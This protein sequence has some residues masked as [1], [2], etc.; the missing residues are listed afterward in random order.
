MTWWLDYNEDTCDGISIFSNNKPNIPKI[1][2]G[3]PVRN[4]EWVLP[5]Y[6]AAIDGVYWLNKEY[7]FL[8]NDSTDST[9]Y[10]LK[11]FNPFSIKMT[12]SDITDK[13]IVCKSCLYPVKI[14]FIKSNAPGHQR[15]EY[16]ANNYSHLA[17]IRNQFIDMFLS[18]DADYLL[19]IDSDIIVPPDI[20]QGLLS[21]ADQNTIVAAAISNIPGQPL[22]GHSP[23]NFMI[24]QGG[25][26]I[27]PYE[28]PLTGTMEVDVTGA[29]YLIPR[30]VLEDGVKYG[31][32]EQGE[33]IYFCRQAKEKGYRLV[34]NF[35][36]R[37][38]H[39][40][41]EK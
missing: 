30:K 17:N 39:R 38:K 12:K 10:M 32:H 9:P 26:I 36:C 1:A 37:A 33:D 21:L 28:Y 7:L 34:V 23:G 13:T 31:A 18:T 3:C 41:V 5:E 11:K 8:E 2:I 27:H 40:M 35:D 29:V 24:N 4:R 20:L 15:G 25:M 22:D 14:Q 16:N 6:L 19:S